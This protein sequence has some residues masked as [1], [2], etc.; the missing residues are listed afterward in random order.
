MIARYNVINN[1]VMYVNLEITTLKGH[2]LKQ[3]L[4]VL[5]RQRHMAEHHIINPKQVSMV[6]STQATIY[7]PKP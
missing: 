6:Q 4:S 1:I 7:Q 2:K 3:L 5:L